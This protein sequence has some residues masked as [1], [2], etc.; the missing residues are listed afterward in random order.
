MFNAFTFEKSIFNDASDLEVYVEVDRSPV[1]QSE[2][3]LVQEPFLFCENYITKKLQYNFL[4][5]A[6]SFSHPSFYAYKTI[7]GLKWNQAG[8]FG[9]QVNLVYEKPRQYVFHQTNVDPFQYITASGKRIAPPK[10]RTDAGTIPRICWSIPG[11]DPWSALPAFVIHDWQYIE[12]KCV[13]PDAYTFEEVNDILAEALYTM[14][15]LKMLPEDWRV[16]AAIHRAVNSFIGKRMWD[17]KPDE[18]TC[19]YDLAKDLA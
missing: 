10:F 3:D 7:T 19:N 13:N 16:V 11:F 2:L 14:M 6:G 8:S 9:G 12:H 17:K 18:A 4:W 1:Q 5:N 15:L